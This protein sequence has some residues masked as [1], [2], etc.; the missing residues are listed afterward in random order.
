[1]P[2]TFVPTVN[3]QID[4]LDTSA[5]NEL[6]EAAADSVE[7][8]IYNALT[9]AESMEGP[10][11]VHAEALPLDTLQELMEKHYVPVPFA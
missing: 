10:S 2:N 11:G 1:M 5:I 4:L 9:S 6:F 3:Q 7:E 8:A